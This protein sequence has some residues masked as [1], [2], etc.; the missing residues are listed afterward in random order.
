MEICGVNSCIETARLNLE[1]L[2]DMISKRVQAL[3]LLLRV[4]D[5]PEH[6]CS[7]WKEKAREVCLKILKRARANNTG[8][9]TT[10]LPIRRTCMAKII[11]SYKN[12]RTDQFADC[13]QY[14]TGFRHRHRLVSYGPE[15]SE[16]K[17]STIRWP[18][19]RPFKYH[20]YCSNSIEVSS[21]IISEFTN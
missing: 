17:G 9:F 7:L 13:L 5:R 3:T 18:A 10:D 12:R 6:R 16:M 15:S 14:V 1:E 4:H 21:V 11:K 2:N 19:K 8:S 20:I